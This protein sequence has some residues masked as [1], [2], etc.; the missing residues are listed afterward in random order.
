MICLTSSCAKFEGKLLSS[1]L[2]TLTH[3]EYVIL[4]L[5]FLFRAGENLCGAPTANMEDETSQ[6]I[7]LCFVL[8]GICGNSSGHHC[9]FDLS[10]IFNYFI[11][12]EC[13]ILVT[14]W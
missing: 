3:N 8:V 5:V 13:S 6:D 2:F 7:S 9:C 11:C 12:F 1:L 14:V 4:P 10:V